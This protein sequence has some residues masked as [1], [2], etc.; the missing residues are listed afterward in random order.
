M[1]IQAYTHYS[2]TLSITVAT[3]RPEAAASTTLTAATIHEDYAAKVRAAL[4]EHKHINPTQTNYAAAYTLQN[5]LPQYQGKPIFVLT[6]LM[7]AGSPRGIDQQFMLEVMTLR[8]QFAL[9]LLP[10]AHL[11]DDITAESKERAI[12]YAVKSLFTYLGIPHTVIPAD[13]TIAGQFDTE[14][15]IMVEL[16]A[17]GCRQGVD[18]PAP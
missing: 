3:P 2:G 14:I 16:G 10:G 8:Y 17:A 7:P 13:N 18:I 15:G 11:T 9:D 1:R 6:Q 4:R 5:Y 12:E